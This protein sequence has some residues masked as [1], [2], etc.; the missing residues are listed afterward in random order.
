MKRREFM[1]VICGGALA[2]WRRWRMTVMLLSLTIPGLALGAGEQWDF[3]RSD[4]DMTLFYGIP[5]SDD[6][7]V[8]IVCDPAR[9]QIDLINLV[10]PPKPRL[11]TT[12]KVKLSN[13]SGTREY[14]GKVGRDRNG[15]PFFSE[16]RLGFDGDLFDFL[17]TGS[18]LTV[19]VPGKR[20][21]IPLAGLSKPLALMRQACLG[22]RS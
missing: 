4:S 11:A 18:R 6:L 17:K 1:S 20:T 19:E 13:G 15:G 12:L 2:A 10:L 21:A 22:G 8:S 7:T 16:S 9:K 5:E 3:V 14:S